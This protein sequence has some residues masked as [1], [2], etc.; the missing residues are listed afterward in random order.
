MH[1]PPPGV[2]TDVLSPGVSIYLGKMDFWTQTFGPAATKEDSR[3]L[4]TH[5]APG[6][7]G[8]TWGD[9]TP[10]PP[11]PPPVDC[12]AFGCNC[13]T[14]MLMYCIVPGKSFGCAPTNVQQWWVAHS[15]DP[16]PLLPCTNSTCPAEGHT[17][18]AT[19]ELATA[20]VNF[21]TGSSQRGLL[22]ASVFI[23]RDANVLL[24]RLSFDKAVTLNVTLSTP[25]IYDLPT[26]ASTSASR[27]GLTLSREANAWITSAVVLSECDAALL[28]SRS[29]RGIILDPTTSRIRWTNGTAAAAGSSIDAVRCPII[30]DHP[31]YGNTTLGS[32]PCGL[33]GGPTDWRFTPS[34][35]GG[36]GTILGAGSAAGYCIA[37][38]SGTTDPVSVAKCATVGAAGVW[39]IAKTG[40]VPEGGYQM[41][42]AAGLPTTAINWGTG[43]TCHRTSSGAATPC[44]AG[45]GCC[46]WEAAGGCLTAPEPMLNIS[47]GIAVVVTLL[48]GTVVV[49]SSSVVNAGGD[50]GSTAVYQIDA[51][52][53]YVV[54]AAIE[55][56]R[57]P[58]VHY[59]H[60]V[61][62]AITLAET[63]DLKALEATHAAWWST[64]WAA[65]TI[66]LGPSNAMLESFYYGAQYMLGSMTQVNGV[67]AGLLGPWSLQDPVG[68]SDHL[69]LDYNVEV[70]GSLVASIPPPPSVELH[71]TSN[72]VETRFTGCACVWACVCARA[73]VSTAHTHSLHAG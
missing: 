25:N 23:P 24:A 63:A 13:T 17:F 42:R 44:S 46:D 11:P 22:S 21:T 2:I 35:A 29:L 45:E 34:G 71:P 10:P 30:I 5:V 8:F 28:S 43:T 16:S 70:M 7:V 40:P 3:H 31:M 72:C 55:T 68:W 6:R 12:K 64:W 9:G 26:T 57:P 32:G 50:P 67:A 48:D 47:L 39:A 59:T 65:S 52:R 36:N 37:A 1:P 38:S 14:A 56:A 27:S 15:C 54:R 61:D 19:Q 20:R 60:P 62:A 4:S 73:R 69:T 49:P 53:E 66:D 51:K 18:T 33:D 41:L 58:E